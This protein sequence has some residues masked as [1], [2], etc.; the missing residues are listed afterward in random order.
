DRFLLGISVYKSFYGLTHNP[1]EISPDPAF[2]YSTPEHREALAALYYGIRRQMGIV[3]LTGE[4]GTGKTLVLR[5][6]V[7]LLSENQ[8]AF[9]YVFNPA[10]SPLQL[11]QYVSG[12]LGLAPEHNKARLL[13]NLNHYL[14]ER[15]RQDKTTV[16]IIDEAQLLQRRALEE[17][18]LLTNLES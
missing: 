15:Y 6:L 1:F 7:N 4:V 13:L 11:L 12:D 10:L 16:L 9:S 17:V 2:F 14:I 8:M 18:R 5:C 3:A